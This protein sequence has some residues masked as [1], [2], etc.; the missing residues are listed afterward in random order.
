MPYLHGGDIYGG[1]GVEID[2]SVNTTPFGVPPAVLQAV[3]SCREEILLYPD[4]QCRLLRTALA[5]YWTEQL[6]SGAD[7]EDK[8][9]KFQIPASHFICGTGRRI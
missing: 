2:F 8:I 4:S 6:S 7:E 9:K 1:A 3:A 5:E